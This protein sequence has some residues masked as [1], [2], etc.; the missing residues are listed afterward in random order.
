MRF[1]RVNH[2]PA[3]RSFLRVAFATPLALLL[4]GCGEQTTKPKTIDK[5]CR[6]CSG[7]GRKTGPCAVCRGSGSRGFLDARPIPCQSCG[8][9][10]SVAML[11][12][13]CSGT[14]KELDNSLAV[15]A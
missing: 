11:C 8:G 4:A 1:L 2:E 12:P 10:G 3:R 5:N 13:R 9:T 15:P 6:E 7:S 14:G